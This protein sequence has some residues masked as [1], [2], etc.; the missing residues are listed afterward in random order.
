MVMRYRPLFSLSILL[1]CSPLDMDQL[2]AAH[3]PTTMNNVAH[4]IAKES[5]NTSS[6][7]N[8]QAIYRLVLR[9]KTPKLNAGETVNVEIY[10]TGAGK[11]AKSKLHI[12]W[13]SDEVIDSIQPGV[14]QTWFGSRF[15]KATQGYVLFVRD[16]PLEKRLISEGD[17]FCPG[18]TVVVPPEIFELPGNSSDLKDFELGPRTNYIK[19]N[20]MPSQ[21]SHA[22]SE[23]S[24]SNVRYEDKRTARAATRN[25]A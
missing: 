15:D 3:S 14:I 12:Q 13:S 7:Q 23:S 21:S 19:L 5:L 24:V 20:Q 8:Q 9:N 2:Q 17:T 1:A 25:V 4:R 6:A 11:P 22:P 16:K 10:L 18:M